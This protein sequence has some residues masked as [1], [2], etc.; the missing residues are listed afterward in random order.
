MII[1]WFEFIYNIV[2]FIYIYGN[3]IFFKYHWEEFDV[4]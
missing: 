1:E 4:N 3:Y 2:Y